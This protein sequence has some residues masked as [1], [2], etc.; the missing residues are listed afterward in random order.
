MKKNIIILLVLAT[1]CAP[2]A[3]KKLPECKQHGHVINA[4]N[5]ELYAEVIEADNSFVTTYV[6][7]PDMFAKDKAVVL[8][9]MDPRL[10]PN[11]FMG[12][13]S[14]DMYVFR[15]AGGLATEDALRSII[16]A[17]KL[18]GAREIFVIQHTDCAM[19]KFTNDVM[20]DLLKE[21]IV[22]AKLA[23]PCEVTVKP[24][25]CDW[26]N[27]CACSGKKDCI[28][29]GCID[30][31]A[32]RVNLYKSVIDTVRTIRNHPLI[33]SNVPIYGFIFDVITGEL[34]PVKKATKIGRAKPLDCTK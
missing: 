6:A 20:T 1:F 25:E 8:T 4:N 14:G 19:Q 9:C 33:P 28:E 5:S 32:I 15:N 26:K 7:Q 29:Y 23:H 12:F 22:T 11:A 18:L 3:S 21:S 30:W 13:V 31:L 16:L 24:K 27:V 10:T 34:I 17:Y 2:I